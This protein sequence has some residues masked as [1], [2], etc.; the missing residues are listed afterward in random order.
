MPN[1]N[2]SPN[3]DHK[4]LLKRCASTSLSSKLVAHQK[5]FFADMVVEAVTSLDDLLPLDMIGIKKVNGGALE[6]CLLK[7]FLHDKNVLQFCIIYLFLCVS[8]LHMGFLYWYF[9]E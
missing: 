5:D 2:K 3:R 7:Y 6:V 1:N 8:M 9:V 4:E